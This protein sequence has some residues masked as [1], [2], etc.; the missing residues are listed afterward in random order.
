M[1]LNP[2]LAGISQDQAAAITT[3]LLDH[4]H[5]LAAAKAKGD[6][7]ASG[8]AALVTVLPE[9]EGEEKGKKEERH[10]DVKVVEELDGDTL[11]ITNGGTSGSKTG[12]TRNGREGRSRSPK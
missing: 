8:D 7:V 9:G 1:L 3:F 4:L 6:T 2:L 11:A 5:V 10:E 12:R